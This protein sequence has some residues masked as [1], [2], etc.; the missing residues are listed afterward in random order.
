MTFT[1]TI[2]KTQWVFC[3][4]LGR[5]ISGLIIEADASVSKKTMTL[6]DSSYLSIEIDA[7]NKGTKVTWLVEAHCIIWQNSS[8]PD[9]SSMSKSSFISDS[10]LI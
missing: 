3:Q 2:L 4:W 1:L 9:K 10:S 8:L 6:M 5:S 7:L